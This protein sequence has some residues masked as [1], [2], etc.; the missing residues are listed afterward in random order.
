VLNIKVKGEEKGPEGKNKERSDPYCGVWA[1]VYIP[2]GTVLAKRDEPRFTCSNQQG[3]KWGGRG[4]LAWREPR[5]R[6][7]CLLQVS[8]PELSQ[9]HSWRAAG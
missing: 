3:N 2:G 9:V 6:K 7:G 5:E 1:S 8:G 4:C